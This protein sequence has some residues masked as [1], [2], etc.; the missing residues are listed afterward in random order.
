[1]TSP[2]GR[3]SKANVTELEDGLYAVNFVPHELG[4]HTVTVRYR[5]MDIPGSPFQFT[6]GPLQDSGSHRVHAGGPGLARGVESEPAEFNVWTREAGPGSLAISV[7]GPSKAQIDFKD[8]K[9]GSCYVSYVVE[10]PGEYSVGIRFNDE[11]IPESPYKVFIV[12]KAGH[13]DKVKITNL[14][15]E[16]VVLNAPQSFLLSKNGAS[17]SLECKMVSPSGR[18]D[19]CF[20][21]QVGPD[22]YSVRFVPKEE[23]HH[24]LH[25]KLNGVHV[26]G[27]PF[28]IRVGSDGKKDGSVKVSGQGLDRVKT[29][30]K[31]SF[32]I[33]TSNVGAGTL[34]VTVDG[35]S[36]VDMDCNEVEKGYEVSYTP[37]TPGDYF[38]TVKYNGMNVDGS[39][40]KVVVVGGGAVGAKSHL[41]SRR[42]SSS[43]TM[44]T[45][46]HTMIRQESSMFKE[47]S[48]SSRSSSRQ[49]GVQPV[50]VSDAT[51]VT[52]QGEG[53]E[54]PI[55]RKQNSF[56]VDA[57]KAGNN[58]LFVGVFG[59]ETPCDEVVVKHQGE[60]QYGVS[61][62]L[63]DPGQ[64]ILY[65]K[66]GEQHVPGS[67][68][69]IEV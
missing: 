18:E 44:E 9:D 32:I 35:P 42:Q 54:K 24:F 13:A 26:P 58:V 7:E 41:M 2:S 49:A 27:S 53:I 21:S 65:I 64:Y 30:D 14:E 55:I 52:C 16:Q 39:P 67:P 20:I 8:R 61:Y 62:R 10:E 63:T 29:G 69:H 38:V 37:L 43:M 25:A 46:Q 47:S 40:F 6:V 15:E 59:P 11:H 22:E 12:P 48:S 3:S 31:A 1:V 23:G 4:I 50:F 68:F 56:T 36:K 5:E 66:W 34:S 45:I 28:K 33:D 17:G 57:G 60:G 51:Q 19:D